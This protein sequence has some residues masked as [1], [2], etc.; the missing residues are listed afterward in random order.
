[1]AKKSKLPI[2][3]SPAPMK[4]TKSDIARERKWEVEDALRTMQRARELEK[5]KTLMRDVKKL[6][7]EQ[8]KAL[9]N[10]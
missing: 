3:D 1:M 9:K 5:D 8:V 7:N 4:V 6:A 10:I 2:A